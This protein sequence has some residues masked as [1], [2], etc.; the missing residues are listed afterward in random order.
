M[1]GVVTNVYGNTLINSELFRYKKCVR[2]QTVNRSQRTGSDT[3]ERSS[4]RKTM[5][6]V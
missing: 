6:V 1:V 4:G 5:L 3:A 2:F